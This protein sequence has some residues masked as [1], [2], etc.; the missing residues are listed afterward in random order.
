MAEA[1]GSLSA[2]DVM[3]VLSSFGYESRG[4]DTGLAIDSFDQW[5]NPAHAMLNPACV[6]GLSNAS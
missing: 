4:E 1:N 6:T 5:T 2:S 3:A